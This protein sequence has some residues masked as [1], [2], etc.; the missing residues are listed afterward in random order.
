MKASLK[1]HALREAQRVM[2][3]HDS[4]LMM[5]LALPVRLRTTWKGENMN[6]CWVRHAGKEVVPHSPRMRQAPPS[7]GRV[8]AF[9]TVCT[10][11]LAHCPT[12][13]ENE[14][15]TGTLTLRFQ[16]TAVSQDKHFQPDKIISSKPNQENFEIPLFGNVQTK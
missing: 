11:I 13:T 2:E 8:R 4:L 12:V 5:A 1:A 6:Q 16:T 7:L 14:S 9:L 3:L 15:Y 10:L